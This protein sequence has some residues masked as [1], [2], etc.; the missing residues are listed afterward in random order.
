MKQRTTQ[1]CL[2]RRCKIVEYE[3]MTLVLNQLD[4]T[5]GRNHKACSKLIYCF[6]SL[7]IKSFIDHGTLVAKW[8]NSRFT[9][10]SCTGRQLIIFRLEGKGQTRETQLECQQRDIGCVL[11]VFI[12]LLGSST[13]GPGPGLGG[14]A[15]DLPRG[16]CLGPLGRSGPLGFLGA[17]CLLFL[18]GFLGRWTGSSSF[19]DS[20]L[21][22]LFGSD[23]LLL[24]HL[25]LCGLLVH[26][27]R[28]RGPTAFGPDQRLVGHQALDGDQD[29]AF[30]LIHI[31]SAVLQLFL[32][33][34]QGHASA[35]RGAGCGLQDEFGQGGSRISLSGPGSPFGRFARG[36]HG[37]SSR[38]RRHRGKKMV[39]L[40]RQSVISAGL[41]STPGPYKASVRAV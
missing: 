6:L 27:E 26:L 21:L 30:V 28:A 23:L 31:I 24:H 13:S 25:L 35:L 38:G 17:L 1:T 39:V 32:Q 29:S 34:C 33:R 9:S 40:V 16:L 11:E 20:G 19:L 15:F 5:H 37:H 12:S 7:T 18:G 3:E 36:R 4:C 41:M 10:S 22:D 14:L 2:V 8:K